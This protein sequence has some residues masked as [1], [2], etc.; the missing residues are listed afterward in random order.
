M[1]YK[2]VELSIDILD[3][4]STPADC[5]AAHEKAVLFAK[6]KKLK[7]KVARSSFACSVTNLIIH[8]TELIMPD[9][10]YF[11]PRVVLREDYVEYLLRSLWC[12]LTLIKRFA[13]L[14]KQVPCIML[15]CFQSLS[16][17]R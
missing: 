6:L 9:T 8:A 17:S 13:F 16:Y 11:F 10:V 4:S 5:K 12:Y 1:W 7:F 3:L 2:N 14:K 15:S